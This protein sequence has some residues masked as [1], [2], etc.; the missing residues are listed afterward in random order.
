MA[1]HAVKRTVSEM[2]IVISLAIVG[3]LSGALVEKARVLSFEAQGAAIVPP[4]LVTIAPHAFEYREATEYFRNGFAIDAP[5][6][7]EAVTVPIDIMKYQVSQ[8]EYRRC[9]SEAACIPSEA[10]ASLPDDNVPVTGVSYDDAVR[11]ATWL[12]YRT[13]REWT[14]PTDFEL[15]YAAADRFP[16]DALGIDPNDRN[17]ANRWLADYEREARRSASIDPRPQPKGSFGVSQTGLV[18]FAGNIWEWTS[19]CSSRID[20]DKVKTVED[21]NPLTCGIMITAG[22]H[23]SP[24]NSFVR[25]PRGGGCSVGTPPDNLGFRLVR[26]PT[27][28]ESI[29][30]SARQ[31]TTRFL[32]PV[33]KT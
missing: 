1:P 6:R 20:L 27:L 31:A 8:A 10:A 29:A 14:L 21:L 30:N 32:S 15:A 18:D 28:L 33:I 19:T 3:L 12:S 11:Y 2:S 5:K 23:R 16:D 22:R 7:L 25:T 13:G 26:R 4:E 24:M 17:P 9:V